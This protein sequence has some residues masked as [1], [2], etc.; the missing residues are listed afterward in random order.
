MPLAYYSRAAE[1][2]F[3]SEH[4]RGHSVEELLATAK[5]SPLTDLILR[6]LPSRGRVLEAGCGL[7]QYVLL[8]RDRDYRAVGVD[9]SADALRQCRAFAMTTPLAVMDLCQ[10]G[11]RSGTF[12]A[13]LSL[14][15]VEHD[16]ESPE[17]ILREAR[18]VLEPGGV[19]ILS[20]PFVNGVR[21]LGAWW[22]RHRNRK[23]RKAG[24]RFYQFAFSRF[25]ARAFLERNG[26]R[27]LWARPYDPVRLFR[28]LMLRILGNGA[29]RQ[30]F[31]TSASRGLK[32]GPRPR[33]PILKLIRRLL[34]TSPAVGLLGHMILLVAVKTE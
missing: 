21:R 25:E 13:Y 29:Y 15:V 5:R 12:A 9:W 10:L 23:V 32:K 11:F 14:G 7:G 26:F 3:W 17:A 34:Y 22:I 4:W 1:A 20:V 28:C 16:P 8:L 24:G 27:I 30:P 2:E 19:L 18:R 6:A 33:N 31:N